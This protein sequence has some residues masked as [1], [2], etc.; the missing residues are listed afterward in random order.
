MT[1]VIGSWLLGAAWL[2]ASLGT[3]LVYARTGRWLR[4]SRPWGGPRRRIIPSATLAVA[5]L[6][7][8]IADGHFDPLLGK[9][10]LLGF[11]QVLA[12]SR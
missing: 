4:E 11:H 8:V 12:W 5:A 3:Y 1:D 6:V 10:A 2:S 7:V 9:G